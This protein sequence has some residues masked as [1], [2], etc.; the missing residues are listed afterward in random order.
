MLGSV[1]GW[2]CLDVKNLCQQKDIGAPGKT[3]RKAID[4]TGES[5][6]APVVRTQA[7]AA[8]VCV[9]VCVCVCEHAQL[10]PTLCVRMDYSPPGSSVHGIFQAKILEWVAICSSRGSS[11][12][13]IEPTS[14]VRPL[15][16][17][18]IPWSG[19]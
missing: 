14:P 6:G 7:F 17:R 4:L 8:V 9:C 18:F 12:P 1:G 15:G 10:C 3:A 16:P 19:N 13:G 2:P 11:L 5:P